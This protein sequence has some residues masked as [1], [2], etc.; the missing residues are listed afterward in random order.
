MNTLA[1]TILVLAAAANLF[2]QESGKQ[3]P[4]GKQ[5]PDKPTG[6]TGML[7]EKSFAALHTL[8]TEQ[9]PPLHGTMVKIGDDN[10]Y[11]S[12]PAGK[13][14]FPAVVVI[15]EWWGLNDHIKHWTDRLAA[16]GYAALAVDLYGGTVATTRDDAMKAMKAVDADKAR[17]SL[18]R[19]HQF[20]KDD[21]RVKASKR[22]CIGWCFGG[23][24]SLELAMAA[25]DL[26][27]AVIYYGM[28]VTDPAELKKIH[29]PVLGIFGTKDPSIPPAEVEKFAAAMKTAGKELLV[30]SY[31]AP[32]AFA[33]PS[34]QAY[35][36]ENATK[37]W[38][39]TRAFLAQ[40]L[41]GQAAEASAPKAPAP[42]KE[43]GK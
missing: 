9:A 7:D 34:G 37:A 18:L 11:L 19:A 24:W 6:L 30:H 33:N 2:A 40:H 14:P 27:A 28:L 35:D 29:A 36:Q 3:A 13:G 8:K 12:L 22:G 25:P 16:D 4:P 10:D 17:A 42:G 1:R 31:E 32:H 15:H 43:P 39:E 38:A 20:L 23:H 5:E 26:D 41:K 21:A